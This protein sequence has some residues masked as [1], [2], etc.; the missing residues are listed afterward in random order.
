MPIYDLEL[1]FSFFT[2]HTVNYYIKHT[3]I[4]YSKRPPRTPTVAMR[5]QKT[6]MQ[7]SQKYMQYLKLSFVL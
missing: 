4:G 6:Y 5:E 3:E 7:L 2:Q 1:K